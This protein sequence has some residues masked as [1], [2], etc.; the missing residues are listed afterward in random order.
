V[1]PDPTDPALVC[2]ACG[3]AGEREGELCPDHG[4]AFVDAAVRARHPRDRNL[5]R[6]VEGRYAIVAILGRGAQGAVYRALDRR[7]GRAVALK[8]I[9]HRPGDDHERLAERF[10]REALHISRLRSAHAVTL[11]DYSE[12]ED[13]DL[14]MVLEYLDGRSLRAVM[15]AEG[16]FPAERAGR[17]AVQV[18]DALLEAH[19]AG[20]VHR[21][22]KPE[23][24]MLV[25]DAKG[26][27]RAKVLDFGIAKF[28]ERDDG[29]TTL[30]AEGSVIGTP[31]YM[32]PEQA[33][34]EDVV[35]QTDLYALGVLLY[36]MVVGAPPY[37]GS[38][39]FEVLRQHTD[40]PVPQLPT[41]VDVG[42]LSGIVGRAMA[43]SP[44]DRFPSAD[45]MAEALMAALKLTEERSGVHAR[46]PAT[47]P[48]LDLAD[49]TLEPA[50]TARLT[51]APTESLVGEQRPRAPTPPASEQVEGRRRF[52]AGL[53]GLVAVGV[54]VAWGLR[55]RRA[56][57]TATATVISGDVESVAA[58][59][60]ARSDAAPPDAAAC[61]GQD[62]TVRD[63][64]AP[65]A[66]APTRPEAVRRV[67]RP[68]PARPPAARK[69]PRKRV[70]A[71]PEKVYVPEL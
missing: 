62:A 21:D 63:A 43:K 60:P 30:T 53:A 40:A 66:A 52:L 71:R 15:S 2:A 65:D 36:E 69:A 58:A 9:H 70:P 37:V 25:P 4:V 23:N 49:T 7:L 13:G 57:E 26:R 51:P 34:G 11:L 55:G 56:A 38:T 47:G 48:A 28:L 8:F 44:V 1:A 50:P 3:R 39:G 59:A 19:R 31:R 29:Q 6:L 42:G 64:G 24:I 18:L 5:G 27:I 61:A 17:I 35:P 33:Y 54:T 10:R 22:L 12:T 32:A 68:Q 20:L 16:R 41:D 46:L 45:A 14:Y 67:P